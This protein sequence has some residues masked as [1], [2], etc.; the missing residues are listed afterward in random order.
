M[1]H[2]LVVTAVVVHDRQH[3]NLMMRCGPQRTRRIH[4]VAVTLER[5]REAAECLSAM[6][7]A[8]GRG[9]A[10]AEAGTAG[11]AQEAVML[12]EIEDARRPLADIAALHEG[13]VLVLDRRPGLRA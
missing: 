7:G 2:L 1:H 9:Q 3:R 8:D 12:V 11:A 10:I 5:D 13:P 6:R 4:H